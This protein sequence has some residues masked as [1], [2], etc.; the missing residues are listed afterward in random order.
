MSPIKT[1]IKNNRP[2][3]KAVN[4]I[5]ESPVW[6][7]SEGTATVDFEIWS[8]ANESQRT[9]IKTLCASGDIELTIQVLG[10]N[11]EYMSVPFVPAQKQAPVKKQAKK[12]KEQEKPKDPV[13]AIA[14]EKDHIVKVGGTETKQTLESFG[15]KA[16][17]FK[18]DEILPVREVKNGEPEPEKEKP[19]LEGTVI[20]DNSNMNSLGAASADE[21]PAKARKS[22][23]GKT[24]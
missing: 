4:Y 7:P 10:E 8:V 19:E 12:E 13:K 6:L 16:V 9:A 1:I 20:A 15:A 21:K 17:G 3:A 23:S 22:K 24:A 18:D 5:G 11:G 14:E 2:V